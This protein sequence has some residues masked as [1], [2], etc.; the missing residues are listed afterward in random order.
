MGTT[1][2][3]A[4]LVYAGASGTGGTTYNYGATQGAVDVAVVP[5]ADRFALDVHG[6]VSSSPR[7]VLS[8]PADAAAFT[9][10]LE[11]FDVTGRTVRRLID[12]A[13]ITG[14]REISWDGRDDSGASVASAPYFVRL[15][16][17]DH[18][19]SARVMLRR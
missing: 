7:F 16:C 11:I 6:S 5:G 15:Q 18:E 14:K 10:R 9:T 2:D 19:A 3:E 13:G 8:I 12:G 4:V 1:H 17:G